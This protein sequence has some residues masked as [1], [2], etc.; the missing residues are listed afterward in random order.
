MSNRISENLPR[1]LADGPEHCGHRN[2]V[3]I[4]TDYYLKN[5]GGHFET[6]G[7]NELDQI[8]SDDIIAV[9]FLSMEIKRTT[10]SGL[11]PRFAI[12]IQEPASEVQNL[13]KELSSQ[14]KELGSHLP[15]TDPQS[16]CITSV[17]RE[18]F[19]KIVC[20][21]YSPTQ[22]LIQTLM[23]QTRD[24]KVSAN[25]K[26]VAV[27]KLLSRKW[28][29][30][31]PIRD[32]KVADRLGYEKSLNEQEFLSEWWKDWHSALTPSSDNQIH[33][34]LT[35]IREQIRKLAKLK[36]DPSLIRIAD[37]L[38]WDRCKCKDY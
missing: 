29:A 32:N 10:G 9:T 14:I 19:L 13:I 23:T 27:S 15:N 35:E 8:T 33:K 6:Y 24:E 2:P 26:W 18:E 28:P 37:V 11:T 22:N 38:V 20:N 25:K 5:D 16:L 1:Y 17:D 36:V 3:E 31:L 12:E 30:L 34:R 7:Q 21:P 4:V